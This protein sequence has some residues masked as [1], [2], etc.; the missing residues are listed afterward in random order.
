MALFNISY[1][2][3]KD[4]DY[5]RLTSGIKKTVSNWARPLESTW[6]VEWDGTSLELTN[7]VV[8]FM[9]TDDKIFVSGVAKG[10]MSWRGLAKGVVDWINNVVSRLRAA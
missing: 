2:L 1:D 7:A 9:D 10:T 6:L 4:K 3:I 5:T 8:Q